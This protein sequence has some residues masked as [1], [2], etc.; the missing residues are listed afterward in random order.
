MLD[1]ITLIDIIFHKFYQL[2]V[3]LVASKSYYSA[4]SYHEQMVAKFLCKQEIL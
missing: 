4:L 3:N 2:N 1:F